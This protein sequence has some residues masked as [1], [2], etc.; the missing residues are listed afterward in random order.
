MSYQNRRYRVENG[1]LIQDWSGKSDPDWF[2]KKADA[3]A[4]VGGP[5]RPVSVPPESA[6]PEGGPEAPPAPEGGPEAPASVPGPDDAYESWKWARLRNEVKA[7]TG[8]GP[9]PGT[10]KAMVIAKLRELD[11]AYKEATAD[12]PPP[13]PPPT[14]WQ[15]TA[16]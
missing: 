6:A 12:A 15:P 7:R 3:W 8:K 9:A 13:P 1:R 16:E 5:P 11:A 2:V 14:D 4:A 10:T